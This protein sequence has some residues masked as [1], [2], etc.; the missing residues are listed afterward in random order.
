MILSA[1]FFLVSSV[2]LVSLSPAVTELVF[3]LG[4]GDEL[5]GVTRFCDYPDAAKR[6]AKVGGFVD[7]SVDAVVALKPTLVVLNPNVANKAFFETLTRL[8]I[9]MLVLNDGDVADFPTMVEQLA[10]ALHREPRGAELRKA[11]SD[12][13]QALHN[14]DKGRSVL[15]L[16]GHQPLVAAGPKSFAADLMTWVGWT[17]AYSGTQRYPNLSYESVLSAKPSLVLDVDMSES[18]DDQLAALGKGRFQYVRVSEPALMRLGTRLPGA[19]KRV[20]ETVQTASRP[21]P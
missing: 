13:M 17:N 19:M 3:A 21:A 18:A 6:I 4:A 16:Y 11:F 2:R 14:L 5:V 8:N 15:W 9:P 7:P 10:K 12:Q 1:I 20:I